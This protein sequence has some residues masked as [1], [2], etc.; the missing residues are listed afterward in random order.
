[1][2]AVIDLENCTASFVSAEGLAV[3]NHHCAYA[4]IQHNSTEERDL[5]ADGFLAMDRSEEL[6]ARPGT[7]ILVTVE[8]QDVTDQVVGGLC[9]GLTGRERYQVIE[10]GEKRL[11]AECEKDEGHRC[12]VHAF[13]GGLEY[14]LI[15]QMEILDVRLVYA[16]A[17]A[18]G[19]YGGDLDNWMWPRHTGDFSFYRAY[20]DKSGKPSEYSP[21]N[22]P[23]RPKHHLTVSVDGLRPGEFVMAAG[24]PAKT[25]RYR[26]ATEVESQFTWYYPTRKRLFLEWLAIIGEETADRPDAK[27]KYANLEAKLNNAT[28]NYDGMLN[29]F[30]KT[31]AV[32]R[33]QRLESDLQEWIESDTARTEK[34]LSSIK[35][36]QNLVAREQATRERAMLYEYLARRGE[37]LKAARTLYRLSKE[38][39]K[40]DMEREPDYQ[41]R[42]FLRIRERLTRIDRAYAPEVDRAFWS[43]FIVNYAA[44]PSD[45]HVAAFDE[46]FG[47]RGNSVDQETLDRILDEMYRKTE[48]GDVETRLAWMEA[49]PSRFEASEDPFI[50]LAVRIFDSDMR[51]EDE[52]KEIE[53]L[54]QAAEPRY[55]EA[56]IDYLRTQGKPVYP[57]ANGTLRVTYGTVRGYSPR[58]AVNYTPFTTLRGVAEKHTGEDPFD[59]PDSQLAAIREEQYG[60]YYDKSL[61][62][63]PVNFLA[64]LDITGGN[65]GSPALNGKAELVGLLFDGN[66]ES[67]IANW[68]FIP[69]ATR[70]IQVDIRY[71]LWVMEQL[72]GAH[73]LLREMGIEPKVG[74]TGSALC[75]GRHAR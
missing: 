2:N 67:I 1:M 30:A 40:P 16:P 53:G 37:L 66:W 13:H 4:S 32:Q 68:D 23:F 59:V 21:E 55:M 47:I 52:E 22:V 19:V 6:P 48:L 36:L 65:S 56:L 44:I 62:D 27:I 38:K 11:I 60:R 57:D 70:S 7:R 43:R 12:D 46:W 73:H 33:K 5:M 26:L 54:F 18:I 71:T 50:K 31:N 45:Q 35:D 15:K 41:E 51:L 24:Y 64:T 72:D 28:K 49:P 10:N 75:P 63:V 34:Y 3:T 17:G 9:G 29:G 61:E 69:G 20:V 74:S 39:E 25:N 14:K 8:V 58:D 42:D